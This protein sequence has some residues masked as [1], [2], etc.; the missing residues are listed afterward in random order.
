MRCRIA[1]NL[2]FCNTLATTPST[3]TVPSTI[4]VTTPTIITPVE[5][6]PVGVQTVRPAQTVTQIRIQTTAQP[7]NAAANTRKGL[8]LT[9]NLI[10]RQYIYIYISKIR[11]TTEFKKDCIFILWIYFLYVARTNVRGSRNV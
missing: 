3:P 5:N 1:L 8:S 11:T 9:V 7:A 6:T 4:L 10:P 2:N